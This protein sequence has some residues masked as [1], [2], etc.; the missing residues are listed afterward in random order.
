MR[1][2]FFRNSFILVLLI[3]RNIIRTLY[4]CCCC[5]I[6]CNKMAALPQGA[7]MACKLRE[8]NRDRDFIVSRLK[9][10]GDKNEAKF[11]SGNKKCKYKYFYTF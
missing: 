7:F 6:D 9:S 4:C 11:F 1:I 3:I 2:R 10:N 5:F 8:Q